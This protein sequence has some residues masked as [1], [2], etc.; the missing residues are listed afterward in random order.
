[1]FCFFFHNIIIHNL[2]SPTRR[3]KSVSNYSDYNGLNNVLKI[4]KR[5]SDESTLKYIFLLINNYNY[6]SILL[7]DIT[8][9]NLN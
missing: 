8:K 9:I 1:M 3:T 6:K 7:L 2:L 4:L 5:L